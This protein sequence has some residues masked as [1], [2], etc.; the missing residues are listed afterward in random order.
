[1]NVPIPSCLALAFAALLGTSCT[2]P[3]PT[4]R[5]VARPEGVRITPADD[6]LRVEIGG[7]LFTEYY[8]TNVPRPFCYPLIGPTGAAMTRHFPMVTN[9]PGE[10]HD[11]RHHRSLWFAHGLVNGQDLWTERP[12][13]GRIVHRGFAEITSGPDVGVITTF[14]DWLDR[15]GQIL[16]TD[17]QTL[18]FYPPKDKALVLDFEITIRA[19]RGNVTLGDTKEGTFAL[20]VAETLRLVPPGVR[21]QP[22]QPGAGRIVLSTGETDDGPSA[23]AARNAKREAVTWGKRAAWC[24]YSGPVDGRIVGIAVLDHPGNPRHPTWWQVRDYG[25][26]AANPF[27]QHDFETGTLR[28]AGDLTLPF[29]QSVSFRYRVILHEGDATQARIAERFTDYVKT[30]SINPGPSKP[31][32]IPTSAP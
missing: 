26:L 9:A 6:H 10:Q 5:F 13:A 20:R 14:N 19:S 1:M 11:H 12:S 28:G 21:G 8:Y 3:T 2:T 25:L 27:G 32:R 22:A 4:P 18:R 16:C 24:D 23:A 29:G 7:R 17:E 30:T 31:G 15:N